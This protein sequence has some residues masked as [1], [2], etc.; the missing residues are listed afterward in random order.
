MLSNSRYAGQERCT[1][2]EEVERSWRHQSVVL[3]RLRGANINCGHAY[4]HRQSKHVRAGR[5]QITT[6]W[7]R[8]ECSGRPNYQC[9]RGPRISRDLFCGEWCR[10]SSGLLSCFYRNRN[11]YV[12]NPDHN[13]HIPHDSLP[14]LQMAQSPY[15]VYNPRFT[16]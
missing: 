13:L 14:F 6:R 16:A 3:L 10:G 7:S 9:I 12:G 11:G 1:H 8:L 5:L 4:S 15:H 2:C